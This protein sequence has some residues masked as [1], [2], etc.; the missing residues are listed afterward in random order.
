MPALLVPV[1]GSVHALKAL[2]VACDLA[3]KYGGQVALLHVLDHNRLAE[4]ILGLP[5]AGTFASELTAALKKAVQD[6][7]QGGPDGA[8]KPIPE[9][10]LTMIGEKILAEADFKVRRRGLETVVLEI[11]KGDPA[12]NILAA[13]EDVGANTIVMG[14]RGQNDEG[15]SGFGSV[16]HKVFQ[17][18][19]CTCISVK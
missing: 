18:A 5:V 8:H 10:V 14:C 6:T 16:S 15:S 11:V 9:K 19:N 4:K 2:H 12:E 1:D 3:D 17:T 13:A 7:G